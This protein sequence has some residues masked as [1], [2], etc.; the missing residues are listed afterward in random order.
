MFF[1]NLVKF[2][3]NQMK[4]LNQHMHNSEFWAFIANWRVFI[5]NLAKLENMCRSC[6]CHS[7]AMKEFFDRKSFSCPLEGFRVVDLANGVCFEEARSVFDMMGATVARS[8][9]ND[10]DAAS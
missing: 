2:I 8:L 4:K 9:P 7:S 5:N 10:L 3:L 6:S 1:P